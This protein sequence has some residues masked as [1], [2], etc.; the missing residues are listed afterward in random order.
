MDIEP[1]QIDDT[2]VYGLRALESRYELDIYKGEMLGFWCS[3]CQQSDETL[4]QIVHSEDC[5]LA[6]RHG[7]Q[8]YGKDLDVIDRNTA[9]ELRTDTFFTILKW[10]TNDDG[11]RVKHR[12]YVAVRCD[13]CGNLDEHLWEIVHDAACR[14]AGPE[15]G[16][17]VEQT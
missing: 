13:E 3:E 17:L 10:G 4:E 12:E 14:L 8:H 1:V 7:R 6:G 11:L 2:V 15:F 5:H 9:G 16:A